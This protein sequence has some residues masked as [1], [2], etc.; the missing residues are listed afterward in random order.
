MTSKAYVT[1]Y[2][3]ATN[4]IRAAQGPAIRTQVVDFS[5]GA[6]ATAL[7]FDANTA[8]VRVY[9][10]SFC[11]VAEG[12]APVATTSSKQMAADATEYWGVRAGD[13]LSFIINSGSGSAIIGKVSID[14]TTPGT[15]NAVAVNA[16]P[17]TGGIPSTARLLSAAGTSGDATN[18]KASAGRVYAIQGTNVATAARYL[19]LYNSASA[20]TAGAGTPVKTLYLPA[21]TAFVFDWPLGLTFSAGIGFT[22]VTGSADNSA[23][24]VT[25]A[26]ILALNLDY[27]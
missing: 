4:G 12:T 27:A 25:A 14:Q 17:A 26:D 10:D 21:A 13:K 8:F 18:V 3:G 6:T 19:K 11:S 9:V 7:P 2:G 15:T 1:E 24:S 22:L 5:G 16:S 23:A 20:P